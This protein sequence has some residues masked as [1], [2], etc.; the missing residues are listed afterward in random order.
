MRFNEGRTIF[1]VV[2]DCKHKA[3]F[4]KGMLWKSRDTVIAGFCED[5][6]FLAPVSKSKVIGIYNKSLGVK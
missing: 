5:H 3:T 1:C 2:K 6:K 4:Y